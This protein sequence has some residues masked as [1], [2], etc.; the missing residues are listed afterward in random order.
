VSIRVA[1]LLCVAISLSSCARKKEEA[2]PPAEG[3]TQASPAQPK[4]IPLPAELVSFTSNDVEILDER[5]S[6]DDAID[7]RYGPSTN[8][9]AVPDAQAL[10]GSKVYVLEQTNG[11]LRFRTS[12]DVGPSVGWI[13]RFASFPVTESDSVR[14]DDVRLLTDIG[15]IV[16]LDA[17]Q[18]DAV[19]RTNVWGQF[20]HHVQKGIGRTLA[21]YCAQRK[22]S[23]SR[24]VD[25]RD[26]EGG[27]KVARYS[28]NMGFSSYLTRQ[29]N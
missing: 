29:T 17:Q 23:S 6:L 1:L 20:D 19:V 21:F 9:P 25:I 22:G 16:H 8:Y 28:E 3:A 13:N 12:P 2:P 27:R 4:P 24:Y 15:L 7:I 5:Y 26:A 18:N 10:K 14:E 11:W